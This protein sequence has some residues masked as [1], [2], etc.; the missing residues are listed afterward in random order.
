MKVRKGKQGK[1][2]RREQAIA[3]MKIWLALGGL[4]EAGQIVLKNTKAKL[5]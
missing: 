5:S 4:S 1:A 2:A 3:N